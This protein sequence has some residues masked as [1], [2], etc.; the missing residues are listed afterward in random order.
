MTPAMQGM[1]AAARDGRYNGPDW[2]RLGSGRLG[3]AAIRL[4]Y[5]YILALY[6]LGR[7]LIIHLNRHGAGPA[8]CR[9]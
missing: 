8:S 3:V 1:G 5:A 6:V 7:E 9:W 2:Y 4:P